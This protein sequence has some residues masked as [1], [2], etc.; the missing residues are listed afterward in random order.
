MSEVHKEI[1][2]HSN[3]QHQHVKSFLHLEQ[4]RETLIDEAVSLCRQNKP[5]DVQKI[6]QVTKEMNH[7]SQRGIVPTRKMVTPE[8]VHEYVKKKF[9]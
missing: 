5:F 9:L 7:L 1:T 2:K 8:M 6:N 4:L 3:S